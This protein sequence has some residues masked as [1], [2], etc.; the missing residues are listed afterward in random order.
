MAITINVNGVPAGGSGQTPQPPTPNPPQQQ[1][2]PP[3]PQPPYQPPTPP[4]PPSGSGGQPPQGG[5]YTRPDFS[6]YTQTQRPGTA[7]PSSDMLVADIRREISSRGVFM[8]PGTNNFSTMMSTLQQQQRSNVMGSVES[9]YN[10][11]MAD[12]DFRRDSLYEEIKNRLDAAR[13]SELSTANSPMEIDR[14]NKRYNKLYEREMTKAEGAFQGEFDAVEAEYQQKRS[15]AEER[16]TEAMHRLTEELS[17]GNRDSYLNQLRDKYKTAVWQRDNAETEEEAREY[18]REAAKIQE[19]M[20][21]AMGAPN[22]TGMKIAGGAITAATILGN[23]WMQTRMINDQMEMGLGLDQSSAILNG[24]AFQAIRQRNEF[25]SQKAST[26]WNAGA[27][28]AGALAGAAIGSMFGGVG[29][30]P[31]YIIG[32]IIGA[33]TGSLGGQAG[34]YYLGGNRERMA[35]NKQA[36]AAELWRQ[37]EGRFSSLTDLAMLT[38]GEEWRVDLVRDWYINPKESAETDAFFKKYPFY[39]PTI[40]SSTEQTNPTPVVVT[41]TEEVSENE[42]RNVQLDNFLNPERQLL[43]PEHTIDNTAAVLTSLRPLLETEQT[44]EN[45]EREIVV[46]TKQPENEQ[47]NVQL[48]DLLLEND[49]LAGI[50]PVAQDHTYVASAARGDYNIKYFQENGRFPG[51]SNADVEARLKREAEQRA[52]EEYRG[53]PLKDAPFK[54]VGDMFTQGWTG[55][56][57]YDLGYDIPRF[58]QQATGRIKQ[59]GFVDDTSIQY[60]LYSDALERVF[61][62]NQGAISQLSRYDRFGN[63]ANQTFSDLALGLANLNTT[64]MQQGRWARSDEFAGYLNQLT[65]QQKSTFL[66]VDDDRAARQVLTGQAVFGNQFG[67]EAMRGIQAINQQVQNPGEGFQK[68]LLYDVIQELFPDTR[69]DIMKIREAQYDPSKQNQ[70]Q[71]AMAKR[72]ESIYGS[73]DTTQGFLA[74]Q[75]FYGIDNPNVLK[76]LVR[77][78]T[79]GGGL[80]AQQLPT[81][82]QEELVKPMTQGGYTPKATQELNAAADIQMAELNKYQ[83]E[84]KGIVSTLLVTI[85]TDVVGALQEAIRELR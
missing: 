37:E 47:R 35:E 79:Q 62:M 55:L 28:A 5:G 50:E 75:Q 16:L 52:E 73:V 38:R 51:E 18:S 77:Q 4:T 6:Q 25:E 48:R 9:E 15:Q 13:Q 61:S 69:G 67:E 30:I 63:N 10:T 56:D 34:A 24:N 80:E 12:I 71:Q 49:I 70:I 54:S 19:R 66:S 44:E 83:A 33:I 8:V 2:T 14:I 43:I 64:G 21:R 68:T 42:Q 84:M 57:V 11:R 36:Q 39:T 46:E 53:T 20:S 78:M 3:T 58:A 85:Q 60:A 31:G 72:I 32:G 59:R 23:A 45:P 17:Q 1:P 82:N 65:G 27:G 7:L 74:F 81:A 29:A 40:T 76:P 26:Q 41:N 22:M